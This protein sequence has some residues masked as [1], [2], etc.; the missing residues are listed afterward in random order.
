ME[1][2]YPTN[3]IGIEDD[4]ESGEVLTQYGEYLGTWR[5]AKDEEQETGVISFTKHG[6][7]EPMFSEGVSFLDS[8]MLTG[9]AKSKL[10]RAINDWHEAEDADQS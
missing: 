2:Q 9:M 10:C 5:F 4:A 1:L 3:L 6:D 8:G 7:A